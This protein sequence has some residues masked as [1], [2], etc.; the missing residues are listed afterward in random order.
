[1]ID[2]TPRGEGTSSRDHHARPAAPDRLIDGEHTRDEH[3]GNPCTRRQAMTHP[4]AANRAGIWTEWR[5]DIPTHKH[6]RARRVAGRR[7]LS[8]RHQFSMRTALAEHRRARPKERII[9]PSLSGHCPAWHKGL[10]FVQ[11][12]FR[13]AF[14]SKDRHP[15]ASRRK[16]RGGAPA[17]AGAEGRYCRARI[18]A[19]LRV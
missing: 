13:H 17:E 1:M 2:G 16:G 11:R 6:G 19:T 15:A 8:M 14:L 12:L 5:C 7:R 9:N 3:P 10:D 18:D 4:T